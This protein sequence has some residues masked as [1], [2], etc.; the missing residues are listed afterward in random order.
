MVIK[1]GT[2]VILVDDDDIIKEFKEKTQG[3]NAG[4][5]TVSLTNYGQVVKS[6][7]GEYPSNDVKDEVE[8][9]YGGS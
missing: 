2:I 7:W 6:G 3:E 8:K 9:K 1:P 5:F 4:R